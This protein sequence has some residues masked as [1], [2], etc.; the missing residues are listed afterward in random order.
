MAVCALTVLDGLGEEATALGGVV[1]L[2]LAL[3]RWPSGTRCFRN[4]LNDSYQW[5]P[6]YTV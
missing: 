6:L 4:I 5:K 3:H 1:V 2:F